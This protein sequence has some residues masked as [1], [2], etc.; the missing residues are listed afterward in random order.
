M[1]C[2]FAKRGRV[3]GHS[4]S[5][6]EVDATG[7]PWCVP[8]WGTDDDELAHHAYASPVKR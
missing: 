4:E 3:C 6:H 7:K 8:C 2:V 1:S 5:R